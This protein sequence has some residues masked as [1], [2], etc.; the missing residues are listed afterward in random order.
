MMKDVAADEDLLEEEKNTEE[1]DEKLSDD[2]EQNKNK[3]DDQDNY[4][5]QVIPTVAR[6]VSA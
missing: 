1:I 3:E 2:L 5:V 6:R 4:T